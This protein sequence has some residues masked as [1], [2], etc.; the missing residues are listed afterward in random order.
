MSPCATV[1]FVR[2]SS[3]YY[4]TE[5]NGTT[6]ADGSI[7]EDGSTKEDGITEEDGSTIKVRGQVDQE[8]GKSVP[9]IFSTHP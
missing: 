2:S 3:D 5:E 7:E 6:E 1:L 9:S 8:G 4:N